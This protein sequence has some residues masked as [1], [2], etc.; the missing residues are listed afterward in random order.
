MI[1]VDEAFEF[2]EP[3]GLT[4]ELLRSR[5]TVVEV[6][7]EA[8]TLQLQE[9]DG[10]CRSLRCHPQVEVLGEEG[11]PL[12]LQALHPGDVVKVEAAPGGPEQ[13]VRRITVLRRFWTEWGSPEL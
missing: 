10:A 13:G 1:E 9:A 3:D 11:E 8:G 2:P 6:G 7:S 4:A 12:D 5:A